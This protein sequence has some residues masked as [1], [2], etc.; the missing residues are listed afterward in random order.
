MANAEIERAKRR[1]K[2]GKKKILGMEGLT[3]AAVFVI[4]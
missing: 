2:R 1:M 4:F 3:I